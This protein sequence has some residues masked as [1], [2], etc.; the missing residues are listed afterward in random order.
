MKLSL[1]S[2]AKDHNNYFITL[3][4]DEILIFD[5]YTVVGFLGT[6]IERVMTTVESWK[7]FYNKRIFQNILMTKV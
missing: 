7:A 4:D 6:E 2:Q 1:E 5:I 3:T